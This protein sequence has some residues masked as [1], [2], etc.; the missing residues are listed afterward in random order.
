MCVCVGWLNYYYLPNG[1][2][3]KLNPFPCSVLVLPIFYGNKAVTDQFT[4]WLIFIKNSQ[5]VEIRLKNGKIPENHFFSHSISSL[6]KLRSNSPVIQIMSS[7]RSTSTW[8][9]PSRGSP[10]SPSPPSSPGHRASGMATKNATCSQTTP[11]FNSSHKVLRAFQD[12]PNSYVFIH[13]YIRS[14]YLYIRVQLPALHYFLSA[15]HYSLY[16]ALGLGLDSISLTIV[17]A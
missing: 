8:S 6:W 5:K 2:N 13:P 7:S 10:S 3:F 11:V 14:I 9:T 4:R 17:S 1:I 15:R 16:H 12:L